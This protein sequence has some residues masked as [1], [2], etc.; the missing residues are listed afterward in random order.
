M[1]LIYF[2]LNIENQSIIYH[3]I[4]SLI[5]G[6]FAIKKASHNFDLQRPINI[7][8]AAS[9][10]FS[11]RIRFWSLSVKKNCKKFLFDKKNLPSLCLYRYSPRIDDQ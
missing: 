5:Y 1:N 10:F 2:S 6:K 4:S 11:W 8:I 9:I 3:L 7:L